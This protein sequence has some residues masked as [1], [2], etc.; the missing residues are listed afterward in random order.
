MLVSLVSLAVAH[1][2]LMLSHVL[3]TLLSTPAGAC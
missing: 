3:L 2:C 1:C